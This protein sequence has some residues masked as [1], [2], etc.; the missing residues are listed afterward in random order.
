MSVPRQFTVDS[1]CWYTNQSPDSLQG[2]MPPTPNKGKPFDSNMW[3]ISRPGG[4]SKC[5][6]QIRSS[7]SD[8]LLL[9]GGSLL[10]SL[11][12]IACSWLR[13]QKLLVLHGRRRPTP[14]GGAW[15]SLAHR[16]V[17]LWPLRYVSE[18]RDKCLNCRHWGFTLVNWS[19]QSIFSPSSLVA[20]P[21]RYIF[22]LVY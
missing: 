17:L 3:R 9:W 1:T 19:D 4:R 2:F 18:L 6:L 15:I 20:R 22:I 11:R 10:L 5:S 12:N 16:E 13:Y 21:L 7:S 8:P 14:G